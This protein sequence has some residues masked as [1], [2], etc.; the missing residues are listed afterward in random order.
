MGFGLVDIGHSELEGK[1]AVGRE[2]EA[3]V[4]NIPNILG[5]SSCGLSIVN[6]KINELHY[7]EI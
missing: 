5:T 2:G 1:T 7:M 6:Y 4:V 3:L